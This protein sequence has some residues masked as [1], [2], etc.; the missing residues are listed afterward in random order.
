M[1]GMRRFVDEV[2]L[3]VRG[4]GDEHEITARVLLTPRCASHSAAR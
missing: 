3:V 4:T 1:I 2:E